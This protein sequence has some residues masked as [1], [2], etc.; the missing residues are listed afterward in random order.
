MAK[1]KYF[2]NP[3]TL[4]YEKF[5]LSRWT[6]FL[7]GIGVFS[8][9]IILGF[10]FFIVFSR[11]TDTPYEKKLKSDNIELEAQLENI[12]RRLQGMTN[13]LNKLR[14]K[15]VN[16]YRSIYESE[17][18]DEKQWTI[19]AN[20]EEKYE[21]LRKLPHS[22][23]LIEINKLMDE[24]DKQMAQQ[25]SSFDEILAMA[26]SKKD[27][28]AHIPSI[29]PISNKTLERIGSGFGYRI[30]PF[31]R[32]RRLHAGIDFTAPKG[33]PVYATAQGTVSLVKSDIWGYG[34]HIVIDHG[35]GYETLY[36]HLSK[37]LV[38]RGQKV[39]RGQQIGLVGSTGKSTGS[40][41]HYE[42]HRAGEHINPAFF[43][44]NDLT[45]EEYQ[46]MLEL[47]S[48]ANQSFD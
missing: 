9:S 22:E 12:S 6:L 15:D 14:Q 45:N 40:H 11:F 21:K 3:K 5:K 29:Q 37:F 43:F 35:N 2:F 28:L 17:P 10:I 18:L 8:F 44:Y 46:K 30:D 42:V 27:Y 23:M 20:Y 41:L 48:V 13:E 47:A 39:V 4:N 32:T 19:L 24:L 34:Q 16:V 1:T 26:E 7:R 38:K 36:G 31:Y 25:G 33:T